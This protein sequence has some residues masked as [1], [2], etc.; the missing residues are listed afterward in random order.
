M[1]ML[2]AMAIV[3]T[4]TAAIVKIM[5]VYVD[6]VITAMTVIASVPMLIVLAASQGHTM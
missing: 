6:P 5:T 3:V 2:S 1:T 4:V